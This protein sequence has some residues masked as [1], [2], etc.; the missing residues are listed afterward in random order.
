MFNVQC[1]RPQISLLNDIH[2][3]H[4][5]QP[6]HCLKRLELF[7]F[8]DFN[9]LPKVIRTGVTNLIAVLHKKMGTAEVLAALVH[10]VFNKFHFTQIIDLGSGSGG[11]M[12]DVIQTLKNQSATINLRL[13]LSDTNPHPDVVK[14]INEQ[15]LDYMKYHVD[16]IDA[17]KLENLP[18]GLLTMVA[19]F[20]H[21]DPQTAKTI[22]K[23]A[24]EEGRAILIY[25]IAKN[26]VPILLWW[27]LLPMSLIILILMTWIM[28]PFV[29][30]LTFKQ[31]FF[32]YVIPIIPLV[33]AWDGQA[34]LMRT[35]TFEDINA[36][37]ADFK[38]DDYCW[39]VND[40]K[41]AQGKNQG[42][43]IMGYPKIEE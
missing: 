42:Y 13:L 34:S 40:A 7:E 17:R 22:L 29:R 15:E 6:T 16:A 24:Q 31:I 14:R 33:Y 43:F 2:Y 11:P 19:S 32:T 10:E 39:E 21:M 3:L 37:L 12:P 35:Y 9:G 25:E 26:N 18:D 27:L 20:H 5:N 23:G 1:L 41:N 4:N 8:E 28:T 30:P 38:S 36:L